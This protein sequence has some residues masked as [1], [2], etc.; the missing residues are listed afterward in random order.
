MKKIGSAISATLVVAGLYIGVCSD[1]AEASRNRRSRYE[2]VSYH[3][4]HR[5]GDPHGRYNMWVRGRGYSRPLDEYRD[6]SRL[7][8]GGYRV[9]E[10]HY[11]SYPRY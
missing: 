11:E 2:P 10:Y 4:L 9:Y 5:G 1:A 6:Y 8:P 7:Y 3:M